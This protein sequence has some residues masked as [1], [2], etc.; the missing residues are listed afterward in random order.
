MI[1]LNGVVYSES[2]RIGGDPLRRIDHRLR[3]PQLRYPLIGEATAERVKCEIGC[4]FSEQRCATRIEIRGRNIAEGIPRGFVLDSAEI[5]E[6]P[7]GSR[8]P[9]S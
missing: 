5:L 8:S 9:V 1:S 7:P 6:A 2:V 3:A 4:A